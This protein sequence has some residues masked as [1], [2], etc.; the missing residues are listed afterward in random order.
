MN[1]ITT[2]VDQDTI[3][4]SLISKIA[5]LEPKHVK[6]KSTEDCANQ[7]VV[8]DSH[9]Y[10]KVYK[11]DRYSDWLKMRVIELLAQ[12]YQKILGIEWN[13]TIIELKDSDISYIVEQRQP[14]HSIKISDG[15]TIDQVLSGFK[16]IL[17]KIEA[18]LNLNEI[19]KKLNTDYH[20]RLIR[21]CVPKLD[22]YAIFNNNIILLDD[23]DFFIVPTNS[24]GDACSVET[25]YYLLDNDFVFVPETSVKIEKSY[26]WQSFW[27]IRKIKKNLNGYYSNLKKNLISSTNKEIYRALKPYD[28]FLKKEVTI[29]S[30]LP[31]GVADSSGNFNKY[32]D[33]L[34]VAGNLV[35]DTYLSID[36]LDLNKTKNIVMSIINRDK[37]VYLITTQPNESLLSNVY[38][39]LSDE[40]LYNWINLIIIVTEDT[41]QSILDSIPSLYKI[42]GQRLI[43]ILILGKTLLSYAEYLH[44]VYSVPVNPILGISANNLPNDL[45][46]E[47]QNILVTKNTIT[48]DELLSYI[49]NSTTLLYPLFLSDTEIH[50]VSGYREIPS[51]R[52]IRDVTGYGQQAGLLFKDLISIRDS[53]AF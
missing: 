22:D 44:K 40:K 12:Y 13:L 11:I 6:W 26:T 7:V 16:P 10:Y 23:A 20:L 36:C 38:L 15:Y 51:H 39:L 27:T 9:Y 50:I 32:L 42:L 25:D 41:P 17:E 45:P 8:K 1:H 28:N 35:N 34:S 53:R 33:R 24:N 4:S 49:S 43:V 5:A 37:K 19:E 48:R 46:S 2:K 14:L 31:D 21:K 29:I 47:L 18:E 30:T 3:D 52:L